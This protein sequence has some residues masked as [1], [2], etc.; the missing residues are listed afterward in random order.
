MTQHDRAAVLAASLELAAER[1]GDPTPHVFTRL[2]AEFP[3]MEAM[4]WRD[5]AGLIRGQ[6]LS[7]A[8][9]SLMDLAENGSYGGF[10]LQ[11]ERINH[12]GMGVSPATFD[13]FFHVVQ[14]TFRE[15][16]GADWTPA[17]DEVWHSLIA[18]VA[19]TV[20]TA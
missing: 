11:S 5:S 1:L 14:A 10:L 9:E 16:I 18:D 6:M 8:F 4:F 15:H 20:A 13:S 7:V 19:G 12:D 17:M 2:F 3:E